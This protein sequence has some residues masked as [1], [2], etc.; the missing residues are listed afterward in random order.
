[1]AATF[2]GNI[3]VTLSGTYNNALDL[4]TGTSNFAVQF[5]DALTNGTAVNTADLFWSDQRSV[6]TGTPDDLDLAGGLTD[7]YG[8]TLTFARIKGIYIHNT[9]TTAAEILSVGGDATAAFVNWVDNS[10]DVINVGPD[11]VMFL[12][13]PSAAGYAVTATTGDILQVAS[14]SGTITYNI[15]LIGASA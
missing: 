5:S 8:N 6:A 4:H 10:S 11:G 7:L 14:D 15:V 1:M 12:Y 3:K 9:S 13:T 2:T